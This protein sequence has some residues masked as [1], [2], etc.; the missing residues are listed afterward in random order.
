MCTWIVE[1]LNWIL[2]LVISMAFSIVNIIMAVINLKTAQKQE[3]LQNNSFC[4]QLFDRRME[5]YTSVKTIL[6]KVIQDASV[7][8]QQIDGFSKSTRDVPLLFGDEVRELIDQL[9]TALSRLRTDSVKVEHAS[10]EHT[11]PPNYSE[12][13]D[14]E[15]KS[16][17]QFEELYK[18]LPEALAPYI[19]FAQYR[20]ESQKT[21]K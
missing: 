5:I 19:S 1:N 15:D 18:K 12:L 11:L 9:Y 3:K 8:N 16:F 7:T 2:P 6:T 10:K 17:D 21:R 20:I 13:C 4:Y 14:C